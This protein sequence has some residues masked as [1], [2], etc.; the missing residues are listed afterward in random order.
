MPGWG[1]PSLS[2]AGTRA[3]G[4]I[5]VVVVVVAERDISGVNMVIWHHRIME[6]LPL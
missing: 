1:I 3:P 6:G 5:V 4:F 2:G